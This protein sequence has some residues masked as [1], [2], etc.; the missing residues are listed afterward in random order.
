[1]K[2]E[3]DKGNCRIMLA[4]ITETCDNILTDDLR[5]IKNQFLKSIEMRDI[6]SK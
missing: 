2:T 5:E 4:K 3:R 1:M 6:F